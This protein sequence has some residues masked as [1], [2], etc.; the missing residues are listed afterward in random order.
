[1]TSKEASREP[2]SRSAEL[3]AGL[4]TKGTTMKL[5]KAI[6][7]TFAIASPL[8]LLGSSASAGSGAMQI[9]GQTDFQECSAPPAGYEDSQDPDTGYSFHLSGDLNGC[10]YGVITEGRLHESGTY[11]EVADEI[12]V[13]DENSADTFEMTE[14]YTAKFTSDFSLIFARCK[15]PIITGS[16]TGYFDGISGR[17]D[18]KDDVETGVADYK[19]HLKMG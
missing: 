9:E 13:S 4:D 16:G 18:F 5:A 17:L 14:F 2:P 3:T 15:H 7:T 6:A 19:G 8:F 1:M 10:L 11:Q 12:F